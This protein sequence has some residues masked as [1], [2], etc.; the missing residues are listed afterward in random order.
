MV[1]EYWL[2][3]NAGGSVTANGIAGKVTIRQLAIFKN[4][5]KCHSIW[6]L[7]VSLGLF[8]IKTCGFGR[9]LVVFILCISK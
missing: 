4:Y 5:I 3:N 6:F 8:F 2:S 7:G 9:P 1:I